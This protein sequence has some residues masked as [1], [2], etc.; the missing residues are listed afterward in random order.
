VGISGLH[1]DSVKT[2]SRFSDMYQDI[3]NF[4]PTQISIPYILNS[5]R[6]GSATLT[7]MLHN[8]QGTAMVNIK[9][10]NMSTANVISRDK[11]AFFLEHF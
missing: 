2:K 8:H 4:I 1:M 7:F 3:N 5:R 6:H 9:I 11:G 10:Q